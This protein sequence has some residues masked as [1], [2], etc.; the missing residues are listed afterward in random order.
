MSFSSAWATVRVKGSE[1]SALNA[2]SRSRTRATKA[3]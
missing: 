3:A 2:C 1:G